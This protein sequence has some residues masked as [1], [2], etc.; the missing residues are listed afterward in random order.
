MPLIVM[1]RARMMSTS[2]SVG[3]LA[4]IG[5]RDRVQAGI[6]AYDARLVRPG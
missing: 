2:L 6:F 5:A 3:S 1:S 4:R